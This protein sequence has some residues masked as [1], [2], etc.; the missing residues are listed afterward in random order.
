M[1]TVHKQTET[2][3]SRFSI[4]PVITELLSKL[5]TICPDITTKVYRESGA[6]YKL[7]SGADPKV[8]R[9]VGVREATFCADAA[10]RRH[11]PA[12][13][14]QELPLWGRVTTGTALS[15]DSATQSVLPASFT[16]I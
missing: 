10:A 16:V 11:F 14:L 12:A 5:R 8:G 9:R 7:W 13:S 3:S 4:E 2:L 1:P 15:I 6:E